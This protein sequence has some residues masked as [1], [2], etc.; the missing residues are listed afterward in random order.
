MS[1]IALVLPRDKQDTPGVLGVS[2][3]YRLRWMDFDRNE[4]IQPF[5]ILDIF[6]DVALYQSEDMGIG[7]EDMMAHRVFWAVIRQKIEIIRQP[8]HYQV[9]TA[10]TWPHSLSRFSFMRDNSLR[11][12]AGNLLAKGS[13][14]YVLMNIDTRKFVKVTDILHED[15]AFDDVRA[16]D[17]KLRKLPD[18][19]ADEGGVRTVVPSFCD[20]DK[21]G[22]VNNAMYARYAMDALNPGADLALRTFQI[23]YRREVVEGVPLAVHTHWEGTRAQ[24]KGV[25]EGGEIAFACTLEFDEVDARR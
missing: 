12:E 16:F 17:G 8:D 7:Y 20:V 11:D 23:D 4:R 13:A 24:A 10:R 22:H 15:Y 6:Q 9:A 5:A 1:E 3:D 14:E 21:N 19:E 18:F 25:Y 2:R